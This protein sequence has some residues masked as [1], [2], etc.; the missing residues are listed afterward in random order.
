MRKT[1]VP[2]WVALVLLAT[3]AVAARASAQGL[4][5]IRDAEIENTI[6]AYAT[7]L[8]QAAGL[9]PQAI[10]VYLVQDRSL[11]AFVAGGMNMFIHTGLLM[12]SEDPLQ[13]I[14]VIAHETGHIT[15]GHLAGRK[16]ELKKTVGAVIASYILG[17]G[18]AV[19]S[20]RPDV[21]AA[22]ITGGQSVATRG[23]LS[24][25]RSQEQAADQAAITLLK[26]TRQSPRGLL[27]F[28][29]ILEDQEALLSSSQDPYVR[30]HPLTSDR[31]NFL[32]QAV[33]NS[34]FADQ[35]AGAA[36]TSMHDRMRAKLVGFL[37][38]T[39]RVFRRY[40]EDDTSLAAR[41][42]RAIA[43]YRL[44]D[45]VKALPL[46]DQLISEQPDDPYFLELKGQILF[47]NGRIA[48]SIPEY[49]AA[50]A[51][52]PSSP[53]IRLALAAAQIEAGDAALNDAAL[54]HLS[55]VLRHEPDNA[56]AWRLS[57]ISHGRKGDKAMTTLSLAE[58]SLA[59]GNPRE[60]RQHAQRALQLL[61]EGSAAWL[62][63]DDIR[64]EAERRM[65][66][67]S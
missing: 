27:D 62:R 7:P 59:R 33:V 29:R 4:Q 34:P 32:E 13:V 52:L 9:N 63:A 54:A 42:A 55:E 1:L 65:K 11:N 67:K 58:A 64:H 51:Q 41:Y 2:L 37:E 15:G 46:I 28:L 45:L 21:G 36:F 17:L 31:I 66:R 56:S 48:E 50:L 22:I 40:P 25:S 35:A 44:P 39:D 14:G 49:E 5:L 12:R 19:A 24:Y 26:G 47:E 8:F 3:L 53:Q 57:A 16:D 43:Y 60:A 10:D 30:T 38:P 61:Q 23:L 6:R 20:G 18:A